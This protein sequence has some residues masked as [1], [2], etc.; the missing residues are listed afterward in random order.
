MEHNKVNNMINTNLADYTIDELFTLFDIKIDDTTDYTTLISQIEIKGNKLINTFKDNN[1]HLSLFFEKALKYLTNE[2]TF[3]EDSLTSLI[4]QPNQEHDND[5]LF[6][7]NNSSGNP[8]NRKTV[9]K[10]INI[11]SRFRIDK[12]QLSTN[13]SIKLQNPQS[14]IIEMKLCDL[15][16]PTTYYPISTALNNNYMWIKCHIGLTNEDIYNYIFI[17]DGNYYF[18]NLINYINGIECL[19]S[20]LLSQT[21]LSIF[22]DLNYNNGGGV[23]TGTG[24]ITFGL[25]NEEDVSLNNA[26]DNIDIVELNFGGSP[27]ENVKQTISLTYEDMLLL[28]DKY[29]VN[30]NR[31]IDPYPTFGNL[32]GF[33]QYKYTGNLFYIS[34]SIM[35]IIGPRYLFLVIDDGISSSVNAN[36]F[37]AD[38]SGLPGNTIAR[39]SLKGAA[40]NVQAQNDFS[41]YT[42]PRLYFGPVNISVLN[43]KLIDEYQRIVD[44]NGSNISFTLRL[45]AV[46]TS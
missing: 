20:P 45:T 21:P 15:E 10:L 6:K 4:V 39:I 37:S 44:L 41:V 27:L 11:D 19:K 17:P 26:T 8:I 7:A 28:G 40:F 24:K 1:P 25:F 12:A 34:E 16:L 23:G 33:T 13:F 36:F 3:K 29:N 31:E 46:Y 38:G 2:Q 43:I 22:F 32:L 9:S 14:K 35:D 18:D 30:P 5:Y 42:E